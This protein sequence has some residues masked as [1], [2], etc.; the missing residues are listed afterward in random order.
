MNSIREDI[1]PKLSDDE[2]RHGV[3]LS[4]LDTL[5][6]VANHARF[7]WAV[8]KKHD[9]IRT[10][11]NENVA[12]EAG[13]NR[14]LIRAVTNLTERFNATSYLLVDKRQIPG[15]NFVVTMSAGLD[16]DKLRDGSL[17]SFWAEAF[18]IAQ[19]CVDRLQAAEDKHKTIIK[20]GYNP[21]LQQHL[22][23]E[24]RDALSLGAP[25]FP[26]PYP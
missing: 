3:T 16:R 11:F 22:L 10:L 5:Y 19:A 26:R 14:N 15:T 2:K 25:L 1:W 4:L 8:D 17:Q 6:W 7:R 9:G 12:S 18:P 21:E 23:G 20:D 13:G 24:L